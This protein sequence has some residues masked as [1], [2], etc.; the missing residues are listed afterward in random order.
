LWQRLLTT[1]AKALVVVVAK[2]DKSPLMTMSPGTF[3]VSTVAKI[4]MPETAP[5]VTNHPHATPTTTTTGTDNT[6]EITLKN[7]R[8][9]T[10]MNSMTKMKFITMIILRRTSTMKF[11]MTKILAMLLMTLTLIRTSLTLTLTSLL[12]NS[13]ILTLR[14][15]PLVMNSFKVRT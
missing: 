7:L 10:T 3:A 14:N 4:T 12:M 9:T 13:Q 8:I 1:Q 15:P 11:T 6:V 2:G 5:P